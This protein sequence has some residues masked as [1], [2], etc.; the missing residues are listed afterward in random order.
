MAAMLR[1]SR[2]LRLRKLTR[3]STTRRPATARPRGAA[4][5]PYVRTHHPECA[6]YAL[7]LRLR[8]LNTNHGESANGNADDEV[9]VD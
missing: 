5:G 9:A 8:C 7:P 4:A 2:L 1:V 6:W 3:V